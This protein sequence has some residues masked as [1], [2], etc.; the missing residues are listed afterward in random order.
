MK[1]K[2]LTKKA[3]QPIGPYSQA[4][5]VKKFLYV[6][7]QI[8]LDPKTGK[9]ICDNI[10]IEVHQIMNNIYAILKKVNMDFKDVI[11]VTIYIKSITYLS[12]INKI[13]LNYFLNEDFYPARE[14]VEVS[15]LP[16]N[17]NVEI[18]LIAYKD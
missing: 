1:T 15:D 17:A 18:S 5:Y 7:G 2:I 6:S 9:M 12:N 16:K 11:K 13:Y 10:N 8:S 14:I 4:I 3:P